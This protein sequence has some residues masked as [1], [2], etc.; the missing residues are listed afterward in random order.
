MSPDPSAP[1]SAQE[2]PL[3]YGKLPEIHH[4]FRSDPKNPPVIVSLLF[5]V[6]VLATVPVL[7]GTVRIVPPRRRVQLIVVQWLYL[8]ANVYHLGKAM[9]E[10]PVSHAL[11]Y[12]SIIGLEGIF[13]LYYSSWNLFQTLP[14]VLA[15]G[16]VTF[17]SGSR[18][19]TEVQERRLAGL[20]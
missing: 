11:F 12:G 16:A 14:A 4:T 7:F 1:A 5:T 2:K 6:A 20:R 13:F 3:R 15:V 8:G 17:L 19:L 18:A 9:Q 10:A